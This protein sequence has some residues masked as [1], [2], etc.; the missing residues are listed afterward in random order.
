MYLI[1]DQMTQH[2]IAL[3]FWSELWPY[4]I[5]LVIM[6]GVHEAVSKWEKNRKA[7]NE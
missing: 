2:Q 4:L 5:V 7:D 6:I 1:T 3:Q